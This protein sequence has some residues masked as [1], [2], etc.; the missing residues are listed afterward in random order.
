MYSIIIIKIIPNIEIL[1][2]IYIYNKFYY[3]H[4]NYDFKAFISSNTKVW[5]VPIKDCFPITLN[6]S[7][8]Y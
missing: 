4:N 2:I 5:D 1:S 7:F 8:I 6:V 3:I